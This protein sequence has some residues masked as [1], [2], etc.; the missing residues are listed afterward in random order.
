MS[1]VDQEGIMA[2]VEELLN[3]TL[4]MCVPQMKLPGEHF[5]RI[6]YDDAIERVQERVCVCVSD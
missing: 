4:R 1:F 3:S 2:M 5:P 6:T